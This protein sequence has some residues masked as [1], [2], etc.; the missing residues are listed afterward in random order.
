[1][2]LMQNQSVNPQVLYYADTALRADAELQQLYRDR[3]GVVTN[4]F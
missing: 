3:S 1:M 4:V 2:E